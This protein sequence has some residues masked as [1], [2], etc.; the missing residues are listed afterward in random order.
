M[1]LFNCINELFDSSFLIPKISEFKYSE[2]F[3]ID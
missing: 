3:S 2:F 1:I